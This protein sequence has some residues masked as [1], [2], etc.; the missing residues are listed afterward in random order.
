MSHADYPPLTPETLARATLTFCLDGADALMYAL[1]KGSGSAGEALELVIASRASGH[2]RDDALHRL[3]SAFATGLSRWGR[4]PTT[5]AFG[6]FHRALDAWQARLDLLPSLDWRHL[7]DWFTMDGTQWIIGPDSALWPRQLT[8]LSTRKDWAPPLCL[9]GIGDVC[10]LTCCDSPVAM[11]GSRGVNDYGRGVAR[12]MA[13]IAASDGHVVVSG[14][15][16]GADAAAHWGALSAIQTRADGD[17]GRTVAVFAGGLNHIG[18]PSN[19]ELFERI[20]SSGG[21][22]ISELCPG[23]IPEPRRF[24]IRNRIIAALAST[25]V[26]VQARLRSGALNTAGWANELGRTVAAVPG[27]ITMP[28]NAG[29]NRLISRAEAMMLTST[30]DI[31]ECCHAP[32]PPNHLERRQADGSPTESTPDD[33]LTPSQSALMDAIRFCMKRHAAVTPDALLARLS[34]QS[35]DLQPTV[36]RIMADLGAL[37]A[38]G[39]IECDGTRIIAT[40]RAD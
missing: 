17:C 25:V 39:L 3:D 10:A 24:L 14:G 16:L 37:E 27:D 31:R 12:D 29:C 7:D 18:P 5:Q 4:K 26:I 13:A 23:T 34:G 32:H 28:H 21:A 8:D 40:K 33:G 11:V 20:E 9:W 22:L 2:E 36:A 30:S 35:P 6:V 19:R 38:L 15:A 1:L